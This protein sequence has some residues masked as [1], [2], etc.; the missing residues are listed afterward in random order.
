M[1]VMRRGTV[2]LAGLLGAAATLGTLGGAARA[3][4]VPHSLAV[5]LTARA[6]SD[7][8]AEALVR[9]NFQRLAETFPAFAS[10]PADAS[11]TANTP[12]GTDVLSYAADNVAHIDGPDGDRIVVSSHPL[13]ILGADGR[14]LSVD[15]TLEQN[16]DGVLQ[17]RT[18]PFSLSLSGDP[19]EGFTLGPDETHSLHVTPLSGAPE[20][21]ANL[22]GNEVFATNTHAQG[23]TLLRPTV[24]GLETYEQLRGPDAPE[25]FAWRL[26]L[27]DDQQAELRDGRVVVS[28]GGQTIVEVAAPAAFDADHVVLPTQMELV[29]NVLSVTVKHRASDVA[30]PVLVDPDWQ[31]RYDWTERPGA[32]GP[33]GWFKE[34]ESSTLY[35]AILLISPISGVTPGITISPRKGTGQLFPGGV[36]AA[37][38][39][40]SPGTT[41]IVSAH[42]RAVHEINDSARQTSRLG[43]FEGTPGGQETVDDFST[44]GVVRDVEDVALNGGGFARF[45][46]VRMFTP[47]CTVGGRAPDDCRRIPSDNLTVQHVGAV[48]FTLSD[49][50]LPR[51][52]ASGTLRDLAD[53]WSAPTGT[54]TVVGDFADDGSGI[55]ATGLEATGPPAAA[56][57]APAAIA[58]CDPDHN[59]PELLNQICP[60]HT[61]QS[62]DVDGSG[63]PE[64]RTHFDL[65]AADFAGNASG[66]TGD[67]W[68]VYVDR[69]APTIAPSGSLRDAAGT[70]VD[71]AQLAGGVRLPAS[72]VRSGVASI[73]LDGTDEAGSQLI[74]DTTDTCAPRGPIGS[75]CPT[76]TAVNVP[77]DPDTFTEGRIDLS[78]TAT[79]FA[80]NRS[81]AESWTVHVDRTTPAARAEGDLVA[82]QDQWSNRTA[83]I[84]VTISGRDAGSGVKA[85]RLLA[86]NSN[87]R[88]VLKQVD[89][90]DPTDPDPTDGSCPHR[91]TK[92]VTVDPTALPD[93]KST[94][95]VEA[96]D[97]AGHASRAD[98]SWDTYLD[99]TPP[100]TPTGL[101]VTAKSVDTAAISWNRVTDSPDGSP[102]VSYQYLVKAG[103]QTVVDWTT[104][105]Y[106]SAVIPGLARRVDV[107]VLVRSLDASGNLSHE[108]SGRTKLTG[109]GVIWKVGPAQAASNRRDCVGTFGPLVAGVA[110]SAYPQQVDGLGEPK[111]A[112]AGEAHVSCPVP[113]P[114]VK[115]DVRLT[116]CIKLFGG[117]GPDWH[118]QDCSTAHGKAIAG[119]KVTIACRAGTQSYRIDAEITIDQAFRG[120]LTS[121]GHSDSRS[122]TC[123]NAGAWR[124]SAKANSSR[125]S[126]ALGNSLIA[127]NDN[128]PSSSVNERRR[129]FAAH[130][131]VPATSKRQEAAAVQAIAWACGLGR[132]GNTT[133]I[134]DAENGS[135]LRG[136]KLARAGEGKATQNTPGY[137]SLTAAARARA[138]HPALHTISHFGW[139]AHRLSSALR[140]SNWACDQAAA[141]NQFAG[142]K[143]DLETG[144]YVR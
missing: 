106:P 102:A 142:I 18:A 53:T 70:W 96:V 99:H 27:R 117:S 144:N 21:A 69:T 103:E 110:A 5:P 48:D 141:D 44:T 22:Q 126:T 52:H 30:Y 24:S 81:P 108:T 125:P 97:L 37:L 7:T 2:L 139:I 58:T 72:D 64:G 93:G 38:T 59:T 9:S 17:P 12:A 63:L 76:Q 87:G 47:P 131:I 67:S 82:L 95:E 119:T 32:V 41:K 50:D 101:V 57:V 61:Q 62:F 116:I 73:T 3:A 136:S 34:P 45:A 98:E 111:A 124:Y 10:A 130:H 83:P 20:P 92:A 112:I 74:H 1:T 6:R 118:S 86:L 137:L 19:A 133:T 71:P 26:D 65:T 134:N 15:L 39:W 128:P 78:A 51:T 60:A 129:G 107:T 66:S 89:T 23:D 105:P 33:A 56:R 100:P 28:Q 46:V 109:L 54:R 43:L 40:G 16:G 85:L 143:R 88:T 80:G 91:V 55:A 75:P 121:A 68:D 11:A 31:S 94:F 29:G 35:D 115:Q 49:D 8:H 138:Y 77:L 132:N 14:S 114:G 25:V 122:Y 4:S 135:W 127:E 123:N 120:N 36:Q 13:R 79:D 42:F 104:T 90:C 113:P 140:G 84:D